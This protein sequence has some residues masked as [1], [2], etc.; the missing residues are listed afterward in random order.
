[1]YY[2]IL[3]FKI[4]KIRS[5]KAQYLKNI[6]T[7][8]FKENR[9]FFVRKIDASFL[10]KLQKRPWLQEKYFKP[11]PWEFRVAKNCIYT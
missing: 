6:F 11:A 1:M 10:S 7:I 5:A 4:S 3:I 8:L 9:W 2:A